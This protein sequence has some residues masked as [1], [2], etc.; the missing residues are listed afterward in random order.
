MSGSLRKEGKIAEKLENGFWGQF[1]PFFSHLVP[2]FR[3]GGR[4]EPI[5]EKGMQ[6][7]TFQEKKGDFSVKRGE[8]IQWI[9]GLVRIST[10]KAIQWRGSGHPL[11]RRT[12]QA[13]KLLS[14]S[15]SR[16]SALTGQVTFPICPKW[17]LHQAI[18][19]ASLSC[20]GRELCILNLLSA[21][22]NFGVD[23]RAGNSQ[24]H[25][26][27]VPEIFV[28]VAAGRRSFVFNS[29]AHL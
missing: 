22:V 10:G 12:L 11:N 20:E 14:S 7:S 18:R 26:K 2:V 6:R 4:S 1:F 25:S 21:R 15:P 13:E 9:R 16:K 3:W 27:H 17:G 19:T 28:P 24:P 23:R 29:A 8:A 5:F